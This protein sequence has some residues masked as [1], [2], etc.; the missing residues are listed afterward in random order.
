MANSNTPFGFRPVGHLLGLDWSEK[1]NWY[2]TASSD[3]QAIYKGDV[4]K[5]V[6]GSG[7]GASADGV[8]PLVAQCAAGDLIVG[9]A[10]AFQSNAPLTPTTS[11]VGSGDNPHNMSYRPASTVTYV[12]VVDDPFVIFEVQSD[13]GGAALAAIDIGSNMDILATAGS[14]TTG[15]SAMELDSSDH[16][17]ATAQIRTLRLAPAEKYQ[18]NG[19][20]LG[21]YAKYQV[22]INEHFYKGVVG[23]QGS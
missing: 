3:T 15:V 10:V 13:I 21:N 4:V 17:S 14:T 5:L 2:V 6:T 19:N 12:G 23:I 11:L 1:I 8:Y 9:V 16:K 7:G 18:P 20:V 22:I